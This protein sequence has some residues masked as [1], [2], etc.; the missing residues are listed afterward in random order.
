MDD[1]SPDAKSLVSAFVGSPYI[2]AIFAENYAGAASMLSLG[3]V[4]GLV[5]IQSNFTKLL[6][7]S[8]AVAPVQIIADGSETNTANF[9][10]AYASGAWNVWQHQRALEAGAP[11]FNS[12]AIE[13]RYWFNQAAISKDFL[14]PGSIALIMTV[15]GALLSS[16]VIAREWERG[17]MEALLSTPMTRIE[18]LCSKLFPYYIL[19]I[20]SMLVCTVIAITLFGTPLRGSWI[21]LFTTASLFLGSALGLGLLLS[22][23]TRNQFNAAQAAL[24]MAYLPAMMLSGFIFEISSMPVVVQAVS[25]II[26]ARYFVSALQTLFLAGNIWLLVVINSM[27]LL[28]SALI[29]LIMAYKITP[30]RLD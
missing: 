2:T 20:L 11:L 16:L 6:K 21:L 29:C 14:V 1:H 9:L 25:Y 26:P 24:N 3:S 7:Q 12:I 30:R 23:L 28:G 10:I 22:T 4:R 19:G 15:I 17:T 13:N 5:A 27:F 8:D 18:F